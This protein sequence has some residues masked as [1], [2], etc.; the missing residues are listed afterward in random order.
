MTQNSFDLQT[1]LASYYPIKPSYVCMD[2]RFREREEDPLYQLEAHRS[3]DERLHDY[4]DFYARYNKELERCCEE[5]ISPSK[6]WSHSESFAREQFMVW[7]KLYRTEGLQYFYAPHIDLATRTKHWSSIHTDAFL[8][9]LRVL[10]AKKKLVKKELLPVVREFRKTHA[11]TKEHAKQFGDILKALPAQTSKG[12]YLIRFVGQT[13]AEGDSKELFKFP[14][15]FEK[16]RFQTLSWVQ[17]K[18]ARGLLPST[19]E[20][21]NAM[22]TQRWFADEDYNTRLTIDKEAFYIGPIRYWRDL[23]KDGRLKSREYLNVTEQFPYD[24]NAHGHAIPHSEKNN[25]DTSE[26]NSGEEGI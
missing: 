6:L 22:Y 17:H 12:R 1:Y 20:A 9:R 3:Y 23:I 19:A 8:D 4:H 11:W 5:D 26:G 14:M 2:R 7:V 10:L 13:F 16:E 25:G 24:I 18:Y 15:R 21:I